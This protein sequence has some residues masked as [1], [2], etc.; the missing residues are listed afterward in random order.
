[1]RLSKCKQGNRFS[2][3]TSSRSILELILLTGTNLTLLVIVDLVGTAF[4]NL[5]YLFGMMDSCSNGF[6]DNEQ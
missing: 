5:Y 3:T 1:M 6:F 2:K 4:S